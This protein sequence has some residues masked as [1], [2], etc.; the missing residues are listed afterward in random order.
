MLH[1][2]LHRT[3]RGRQVIRQYRLQR[4]IGRNNNLAG[5]GHA[6]A[7]EIIG[8]NQ[9]MRDKTGL[10]ATGAIT[11]AEYDHGQI[12]VT[13]KSRNA[14]VHRRHRKQRASAFLGLHATGG[15]KT[16]HR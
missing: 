10:S 14:I 16:H 13:H 11:V 6:R 1:Q 2:A 12:V 8:L 15:D 5:K 4:Q 3:C 7:R 9:R